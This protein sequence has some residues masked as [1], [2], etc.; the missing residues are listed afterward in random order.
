MKAAREQAVIQAL[1]RP[2][3]EVTPLAGGSLIRSPRWLE[4]KVSSLKE[5]GRSSRCE[6]D[7]W[8]F[9]PS[10]LDGRRGSA[11][12]R[13]RVERPQRSKDE[14]PWPSRAD[15][16]MEYPGGRSGWLVRPPSVGRRGADGSSIASSR[17]PRAARARV[18]VIGSPRQGGMER[19]GRSRAG[20]IKRAT[21]P[22][23]GVMTLGEHAP[24]CARADHIASAGAGPRQRTWPSRRP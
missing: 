24:G 8:V 15:R 17:W 12:R 11:R 19:C 20:S 3:Y 5:R 13:V 22:P 7:R 18:P 21:T 23:R 4:T 16:R 1:R 14:R 6:E 9:R 2:R 10:L